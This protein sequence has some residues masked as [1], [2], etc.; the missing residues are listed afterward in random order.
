MRTKLITNSPYQFNWYF[1]LLVVGGFSPLTAAAHHSP[2]VHFD[3]SETIEIEGELTEVYWRN[4][5][6]QLIVE[7]IDEQGVKKFWEAE[8]LAPSYLSRQGITSGLLKEGDIIKIK[9]S[10]KLEKMLVKVFNPEFQNY[11]LLDPIFNFYRNAL[12]EFISRSPKEVS[13]NELPINK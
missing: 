7:T 12:L 10:K 2:N 3:R 13:N 1:T 6:V 5:H 4:P 8:Y 9:D 11:C